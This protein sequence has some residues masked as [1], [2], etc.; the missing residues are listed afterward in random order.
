M[1]VSAPYASELARNSGKAYIYYDT[2]SYWNFM[3]TV[4]GDDSDSEQIDSDVPLHWT[5]KPC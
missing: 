3:D 4:V 1:I 2:G 5:M